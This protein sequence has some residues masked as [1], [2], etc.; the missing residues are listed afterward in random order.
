MRNAGLTPE[1]FQRKKDGFL[2]LLKADNTTENPS[3]LVP[4]VPVNEDK[5]YD[6]SDYIGKP[7]PADF[8]AFGASE[9]LTT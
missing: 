4:D 8:E 5:D 6:Y 1:E 2:Q 9:E 3:V 7:D